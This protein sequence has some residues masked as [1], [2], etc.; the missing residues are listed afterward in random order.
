MVEGGAGFGLVDRA[1]PWDSGIA[2]T[3]V[4]TIQSL[5]DSQGEWKMF[6]PVDDDGY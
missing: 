6:R 2:S 5:A 4:S 1:E 3:G